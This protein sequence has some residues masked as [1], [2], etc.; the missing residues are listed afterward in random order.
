MGKMP[1][2]G[3]I[4]RITLFARSKHIQSPELEQLALYICGFWLSVDNIELIALHRD[5]KEWVERVS[6]S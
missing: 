4:Y 5:V 1:N 2:I 3:S 6:L